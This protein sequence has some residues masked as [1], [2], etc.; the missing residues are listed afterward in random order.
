M[1]SQQRPAKKKYDTPPLSTRQG[2]KASN[3]L[4][5]HKQQKKKTNNRCISCMES[6]LKILQE[7]LKHCSDDYVTNDTQSSSLLAEGVETSRVS[8]T[9]RKVLSWVRVVLFPMFARLE[10]A[11]TKSWEF[12]GLPSLDNKVVNNMWRQLRTYDIN[13]SPA[14]QLNCFPPSQNNLQH[15]L[16]ADINDFIWRQQCGSASN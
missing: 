1:I 12:A 6:L 11:S 14:R 5:E 13:K 4:W 16:E 9:L 7:A 10:E 2:K 8:V 3:Y 15:P